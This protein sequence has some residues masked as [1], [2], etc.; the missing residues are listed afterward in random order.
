MRVEDLAV[1]QQSLGDMQES[2]NIDNYCPR[3]AAVCLR[4][5][6]LMFQK[7][8]SNCLHPGQLIKNLDFIALGDLENWFPYSPLG[9]EPGATRG[10]LAPTVMN[11]TVIADSTLFFS[12]NQHFFKNQYKPYASMYFQ[13]VVVRPIGCA[14]IYP[15]V[16]GIPGCKG[17]VVAGLGN[18]TSEYWEHLTLQPKDKSRPTLI[19]LMSSGS[20]F[21]TSKK[22]SKAIEKGYWCGDINQY[23]KVWKFWEHH[24]DYVKRNVPAYSYVGP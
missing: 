10:C 24:C 9:K 7:T 16:P 14:C 4:D 17:K 12:G 3:T 13:D 11:K 6:L 18:V 15:L 5:R 22:S 19:Q 8:Y 23:A 21:A 20:E 1:L 2:K